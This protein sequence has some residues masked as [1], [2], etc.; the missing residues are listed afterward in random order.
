M[1]YY[2]S[3]NIVIKSNKIFYRD[4]EVKKHNWHIKLSELGW[5]KL[6]KVW[7]RKLNRL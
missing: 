2:L 6:N 5:E 1:K 7:I 4:K 3:D